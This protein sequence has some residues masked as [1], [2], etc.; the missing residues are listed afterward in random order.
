MDQRDR[1]TE[2]LHAAGPRLH[3]LLVRLTL[4]EDVAEDLLQAL[5]LKLSA[6]AAF[7]GAHRPEAYALQAAVRLAFDWRRD[8]RRRPPAVALS[9]ELPAG[10]CSPAARLIRT[11]QLDA[12][13]DAI[14]QLHGSSRDAFVLCHIEQL[15]ADLAAELL[16]KTPHQVRALC[17]KALQRLR[18]KLG[19]GEPEVK[20]TGYETA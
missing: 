1:L 6:S 14:G 9:D 12:V 15:P 3:A 2:L 7:A 16:G 13:L 8:R 19:L 10:D 11:E 17:Q 18:R 4:R 20:E 5:F